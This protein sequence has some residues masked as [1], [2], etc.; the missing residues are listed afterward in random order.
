MKPNPLLL[1]LAFLA[2]VSAP[3]AFTNTALDRWQWRHPL[4]QGNDLLGAASGAGKIVLVGKKGTKLVSANHGASWQ[5][6][7][8]NALDCNAVA[9]GAGLFVAVG[10]TP[11]NTNVLMQT[12]PDGL[13][14]TEHTFRGSTAH[15][16]MDIAYGR[17]LFMAAGTG[18]TI[19]VSSNGLTWNEY[20]I[21]ANPA[22]NKI[23]FDGTQFLGLGATPVGASV[24]G[25]HWS[26]FLP[27]GPSDM[28]YGNDIHVWS[29]AGQSYY[30]SIGY[31]V[32][33]DAVTITTNG[34]LISGL[35][36]FVTNSGLADIRA[37]IA[38]GKGKFVAAGS[39]G[40]GV[41]FSSADAVTWSDHSDIVTDEILGV[42]FVEDQFMAFGNHGILL[43]SPDGENWTGNSASARNFRSLTYGSGLHVAVGNEGLLMTSP[44]AVTWTYQTIPTTNNLR[45]VA[46]KDGLFVAV[47]AEDE[48]GTTMLVSSNGLSWQRSYLSTSNGLYDIT[49]STNLFVAVGDNGELQTSSD[50][51]HWFSTNVTCSS[52]SYQP[53]NSIVWG[54]GLF[55][56]VGTHLIYTSSDGIHWTPQAWASTEGDEF[57]A[58]SYGN[59]TFVVSGHD[60]YMWTSTNG[61]V[62][63]NPPRP[64]G[65]DIEDIFFAEGQFVAVG[66][67]GYMATSTNGIVWT[68]R[69][70]Y[71]QNDLRGVAYQGGHFLAVGNNE[72]IL[73]SGFMGP[74][75]LHARG[76]M[77]PEGFELSVE[78]ES[79]RAYTVQASDDLENWDD[80]MSFTNEE[81]TTLF[82]DP[83]AEW[84][85]RRFYRVGAE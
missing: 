46:F 71:C 26:A 18:Q 77:G 60:G 84:W 50:G 82:L 44:D 75:V 30:S 74:P 35:R 24:D 42:A 15:H 73:Q 59:G 25:I 72:T 47:G 21:G 28:A 17:G 13:H 48:G 67:N 66:Q 57:K 69:A 33:F 83:D 20:Y 49:A 58:V 54:G 6:V 55:V 12:S 70:T 1:A 45:G 76:L 16:L 27:L 61:V 53:F 34:V 43:T 3:A 68:E 11:D 29:W 52:G 19:F 31:R 8:M 63:S 7:A 80:V 41:L 10:E 65:R 23:K 56:S 78:G 62:W 9:Y 14:W 40:R 64:T 36:S 79:G 37:R 32:E 81:E 39:T 22:Y 4:P 2:A 85:L 5:S 51:R 38:Y